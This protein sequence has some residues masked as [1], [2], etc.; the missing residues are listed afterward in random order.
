M[1]KTPC[2]IGRTYLSMRHSRSKAVDDRLPWRDTL[3]TPYHSKIYL[4]EDRNFHSLNFKSD[5]LSWCSFTDQ[6]CNLILLRRI[7]IE[8]IIE[9]IMRE[10]YYV[11]C[12]RSWTERTAPCEILIPTPSINGLAVMLAKAGLSALPTIGFEPM[13]LAVWKRYSNRWVK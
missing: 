2:G 3:S 13:T 5:P 4:W 9:T 1:D 12:V 7:F 8:Y 6:S 11:N 10:V